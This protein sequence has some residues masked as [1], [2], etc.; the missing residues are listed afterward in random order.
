V[1]PILS[2]D[3]RLKQD[4]A[5]ACLRADQ[6]MAPRA[7]RF[8]MV[9]HEPVKASQARCAC[10]VQE[11]LTADGKTSLIDVTELLNAQA[12]I[13]RRGTGVGAGETG[14]PV[15]STAKKRDS[16]KSCL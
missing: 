9:L 13:V 5:S 7:A 12:E 3:R 15:E 1:L 2:E 8:G 10:E 16:G 6:E 4:D 11:G 14:V